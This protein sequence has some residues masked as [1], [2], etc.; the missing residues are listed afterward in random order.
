MLFP[1]TGPLKSGVVSLEAKKST[2]GKYAF[3]T[4]LVEL[5][6]KTLTGTSGAAAATAAA[7]K[8]Q[9]QFRV[10]DAAAGAPA[11]ECL[12]TPAAADPKS[13]S[14]S[15][16]SSGCSSV[17]E[18]KQDNPAVLYIV[19]GPQ[20]TF[21][22]VDR[23]S[24]AGSPGTSGDASADQA[25]S[26]AASISS[27]DSSRQALQQRV[28]SAAVLLEQLKH[29]LM[30]AL[31]QNIVVYET[32]DELEGLGYNIVLEMDPE[33]LTF[34]DRAKQGA[35]V[36]FKGSVHYGKLAGCQVI[37]LLHRSLAAVK[38]AAVV[39]VP[40]KTASG[41]TAA[42]APPS[43]AGVAPATAPSGQQQQGPLQD[44]SKVVEP[45][46]IPANSNIG[47]R[48]SSSSS[49]GKKESSSNNSPASTEHLTIDGDFRKP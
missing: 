10:A 6:S 32:E 16:S 18:I 19:G 42:A 26:A 36:V 15:G 17:G 37:G 25:V 28:P 49:I 27:G 35:G 14:S 46:E 22:S 44:V 41:T 45:S 5:P 9:Q 12:Q 43:L 4:L 20:N 3:K 38:Q 11:P 1:L 40:G 30:L 48:D 7:A 33:Q 23:A 8:A 24:G 31:Q 2:N 13:S 39:K 29:P 21:S 47:S 34:W